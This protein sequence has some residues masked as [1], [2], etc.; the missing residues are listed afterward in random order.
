MLAPANTPA[1]IVKLLNST[2]NKVMEEPS[3]KTQLLNQG[4][5][6]TP[7]TPEEFIK[8]IQEDREKWA[9]VVQANAAKV[10]K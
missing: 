7:T 5:E 4:L 3:I 8:F 1:P 6:P 9:K 10:N 2:L